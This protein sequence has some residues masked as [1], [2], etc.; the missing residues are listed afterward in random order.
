MVVT[1]RTNTAD[2]ESSTKKQTRLAHNSSMLFHSFS[3]IPTSQ[4]SHP[5]TLNNANVSLYPETEQTVKNGAKEY[6]CTCTCET[7]NTDSSHFV[8]IVGGCAAVVFALVF[9][10]A[11]AARLFKTSKAFVYV[12][13]QH[14]YINFSSPK[15]NIIHGIG[16]SHK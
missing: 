3:S 8:F 6:G 11:V 16:T 10:I 14:C 9:A 15:C 4:F 5:Y 13:I 7:K 1:S 2:L 12:H